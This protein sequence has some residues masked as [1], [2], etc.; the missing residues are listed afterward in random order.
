MADEFDRAQ[1]LELLN[2]QQSLAA[3]AEIAR[4]TP[5]LQATGECLAPRCGEPLPAGQLFCGPAC[6]QFHARY[7]R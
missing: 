2:L 3:Q 6:A 4:A 7:S 5:K 1:E